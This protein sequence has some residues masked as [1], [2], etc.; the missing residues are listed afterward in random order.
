MKI[1]QVM[2]EFLFGGAEIMCENLSVELK[3]L[4]HDV[5][6]I[7]LYSLDTPITKRL[8][9]NGIKVIFLNKKSGLDISIILK[10][11]KIFKSEKPD[12]IHTHRYV[13]EYVVPAA[14]GLHIRKIHT[15]HSIASKENTKFGRMLNH[16][17][18]NVNS[19][20]PV[21][22]SKNVLKTVVEEYK[23]S[24]NDIYIVYNG[25]NVDIKNRK[26][27]YHIDN[28][29][30]LVHVGR[31]AVAKNHK[32]LLEAVLEM[33]TKGV[34]ISL[35][36]VGDGELKDEIYYYA[37]KNK[38][39]D[40]VHF[41]GTT[42]N[43]YF[44]FENADAFILPSIYEGMPMTLIEAMGYGMPIIAS[45]V[46]GIP[47][48][49]EN[50]MNG[51]LVEPT[52]DSICTGIQKMILGGDVIRKKYGENAILSSTRFTSERMVEEYI[53]IYEDR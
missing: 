13:M 18:F 43:I 40:Y 41:V 20:K 22:L 29:F 46:G 48:M 2:P 47:N 52:I 42:D 30:K 37:E 34:D 7:S 15:L 19:V 36:L 27:S 26:E 14:I 49:I 8:E 32:I 23:L 24:E 1:V 16:I 38:M 11:R 6:V 12:I 3:K 51:I 35:T 45:N 33:R 53:K 21:A 39:M 9:G 31:F 5:I 25:V 17:F 10:L 50:D 28:K 4:G 44:Y